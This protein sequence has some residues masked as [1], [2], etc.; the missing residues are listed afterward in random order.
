MQPTIE[1]EICNYPANAENPTERFVKSLISEARKP[2][3]KYQWKRVRE[4]K[5]GFRLRDSNGSETYLTRDSQDEGHVQYSLHGFTPE[6]DAFVSG[7]E[8]A[9][10]GR[11]AESDLHTLYT[12]LEQ[13]VP[14]VFTSP[15]TSA[16]KQLF[17]S[18]MA[19]RLVSALTV[20]ARNLKSVLWTPQQDTGQIYRSYHAE[21]TSPGSKISIIPDSIGDDFTT[22][23]FVYEVDGQEIVS[24]VETAPVE[25]HSP[26]RDLYFAVAG[27]DICEEPPE[28]T[29][30]A[31]FIASLRE[32][33][34]LDRVLKDDFFQRPALLVLDIFNACNAS[35]VSRAYARTMIQ[36]TANAECTPERMKEFSS[37]ARQL[38]DEVRKIPRNPNGQRFTEKSP[39]IRKPGKEQ[40]DTTALATIANSG[41]SLL[42]EFY[43]GFPEKCAVNRTAHLLLVSILNGK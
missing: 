22:F 9:S 30:I 11:E 41:C 34:F 14:T 17:M 33:D 21:G 13:N 27:K 29:R 23:T 19:E 6:G 12:L 32:K 43:A 40:W 38:I 2:N 28:L 31:R 36:R 39:K 5:E 37:L 16:S 1:I 10:V 18:S 7:I 15:N 42:S 26:L 35:A 24:S 4:P 25:A 8:W 3:G 20:D